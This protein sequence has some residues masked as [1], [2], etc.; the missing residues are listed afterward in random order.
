M[1]HLYRADGL[2]ALEFNFVPTQMHETIRK[3]IGNLGE[4][5]F[6]KGKC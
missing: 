2:P 4:E 1:I 5:A 3:D 6:Q